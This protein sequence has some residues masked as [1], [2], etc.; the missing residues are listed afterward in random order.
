MA[1]N[2]KVDLDKMVKHANRISEIGVKMNSR[3]INVFEDI[4]KMQKYWKGDAYAKLVRIVNTLDDNFNRISNYFCDTLQM[5]IIKKRNQYA[6]A[7]KKATVNPTGTS[8]TKITNIPVKAQGDEIVFNEAKIDDISMKVYERF[9]NVEDD[10]EK[11]L[12]TFDKIT[13]EG[14]TGNVMR[15]ILKERIARTKDVMKKVLNAIKQY[16]NAAKKAMNA[17]EKGN[18]TTSAEVGTSGIDTASSGLNAEG[19][20]FDGGYDWTKN[21]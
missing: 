18:Q 17:A 19:K 9:A 2:N 20:G 4:E 1:V 21:T 14:D 6:K 10:L 8:A 16:I 7:S 3:F 13:W 12:N 5:E 11:I 15:K